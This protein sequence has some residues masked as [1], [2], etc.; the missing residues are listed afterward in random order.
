[1]FSMSM[2][3]GAMPA[4]RASAAAV[5]QVVQPRLDAPETTKRTGF[6]PPPAPAKA[7]TAS[8]ARTADFAIGNSNG[9]SRSP[10]LRYSLKVK[11]MSASSLRPS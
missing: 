1:M 2:T 11:A 10:V 7:C 3:I 8:I 5:S 4:T 9:H 6:A